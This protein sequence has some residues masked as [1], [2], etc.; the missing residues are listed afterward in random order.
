MK[1][2]R[3]ISSYF[4][5]ALF[6]GF[7]TACSPDD[8]D[9][10]LGPAPTSEMVQFT[11]TPSADNPNVFNFTNQTPGTMKAMWDLGN[12]ATAVGEQVT[13]SYAVAGD[14]TIKLTIFTDGGYATNTK[15]IHIENTDVSMLNRE[16]YNFLTGGA[17]DADGK[18][19]VVEKDYPGHMGV[20]PIAAAT[21]EWW[22]APANDKAAEGIY[23]DE[24][25]FNLNGFAYTY[26]NN[27]DT[28]VNGSNAAGLGG[29][30][31]SA[32]YTL[33]YTPPTDM[34]WSIVEEN[35]KKYLDISKDG[36]IAYYTGASRYE[37]LKLTENELYL[38]TTDAANAANGWWLRLVPKGYSR[39][40]EPKPY[41][42]EDIY[43]NFDEEGNVTWKKEAL[44]LEEN[45]DNPAPVPIN[46]SAKVAMY[47]KQEGQP[48]EFAN[49]F[50]DFAYKFD[51]TQRHTFKI[52]VYV[53]SYNDFTTA[54]GE[55][56]A[57]KNLLKQ[58]SIKLQDGTSAQPWVNQVEI[59]QQVDQLDRWV[60]LTFDFSA[61]DV[62]NRKDLDR[63]VIQVGGE[64]NFIPGIFFLDDFRLEE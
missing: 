36:F 49:M 6:I 38:K 25:T 43:D 50:A 35:G 40:V 21:P 2:I 8:S 39:P 4:Y 58:V 53:P 26:N 27:G 62:I 5:M 29:T 32:D 1:F 57:N 54:L 42:M 3:N 61:A 47:V 30:A 18:T 51:L 12:G 55:D 64:G 20:G 9:A 46:T 10:E 15:T 52:K 45:Y 48:F 7:A 41:K 17:A 63:I 34:T 60:E 14:Y 37:I 19:W 28:F 33:S 16:D 13:G 56:W 59:K 22:S 11:A 31:Q 23:D 44:T 24:M